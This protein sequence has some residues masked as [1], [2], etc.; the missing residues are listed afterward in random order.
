MYRCCHAEITVYPEAQLNLDYFWQRDVYS[1]DPF[2]DVVEPAEPFALGLQVVNVGKGGAGN[3]TITSAQPEIIENEKGLLIDFKII[4]SQVGADPGTNSL[5]VA[6]GNIAPGETKTAQWDMISS[7]Q[8]KFKEFSATFEHLDDNGDLRTS[9]I[10][11]VNIHELIR[12]LEVTTPTDDGI[13]DYLVNDVPD[14]DNLPDVLYMS[15]GGQAAVT[16]ASDAVFG[17]GGFTRTLTATMQSGWSYIQMADVLPGFELTSVVRSDGKS[18][19]VDGMAWRTNRTFHAGEPGATYENLFHLLDF[20]STGS[21]TLTYAVVDHSAPTLQTVTGIPAGLI[22]TPVDA[23]D[24]T[25]SEFIDAT[26]LSAADLSLQ[27]NGSTLVVPDL[28]I[29][30]LSG[31]TWRVSGLA[32]VTAA[33]GN[34]RLIVD[35]HGVND[36]GGNAGTNSI[37]VD[38]AM[39]ATSPVILTMQ[40]PSPVLRNTVVNTLDVTFSRAMNASSIDWSDLALTR[41]GSTVAL[42]ASITVTQIDAVTYRIGSLAGFTNL[43][44][45]YALTVLAGATEDSLGAAGVGQFTRNWTM[46]T[47]LPALISIEHLSTNPRN[48]VVSSLDV[49]FSEAINPASFDWQDITLTR[50]GGSNL[51]TS[52]VTVEQVDADTWRIKNFNWKV[53][54]DGTYVLTVLGAG[55]SDLA[56]NAGTGSVAETWVMDIVDPLAT[57][58]L[59][60]SPDNGISSTDLRTNT[61][62]LTLTGD[63]PET[64]LAVRL[65]DT[66]TNKE[67]GYANVTGTHFSGAFTLSGPGQHTIRVRAADAAGNLAP[68]SFLEVFVDLTAPGVA[69]ITGISPNPRT[70]SVDTVAVS[71]D[72]AIDASSFTFADLSLTRDGN[73]VALDGTVTLTKGTG[74]GY[75]IAGLG[76]FTGAPGLYQLTVSAA[77]LSDLAGNAGAGSKSASWATLAVLPTGIRGFVY[78]DLDGSGTYNPDSWNPEI[79]IAGRTV[80]LD[81]NNN[82]S[83]DG[84]EVFTTS[85]ADGNYV[86]DN[87]A[88]GTYRVAQE[89]PA[90]WI[91]T[92][93]ASGT[94][95]VV[96]AEGNVVSGADFGNFRTGS[97]SGIVFDD[98]DADGTRDAG[99]DPLGGWTVFLDTNANDL[100]DSGEASVVTGVDGAF[101]FTGIGPGTLLVGELAQAGWQR[102][103]PNKPGTIKSGFIL[104][105]DIGNSQLASIAGAKF[106]DLNGNG[107]A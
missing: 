81:A 102:T 49:D 6:L 14:P 76:A 90:G 97:I 15:T 83:L 105:S 59:A 106:N 58:N 43:E 29:G 19:P 99:E 104:S 66:T 38:W 64:G 27:F 1:D 12:S 28:T 53:G 2:T 17:G 51:I 93:P 77:G 10:K 73:D 16:L 41:N 50:D 11:Q 20:N 75:N 13:P 60:I 9:L 33:D 42:N 46:D 25:F 67:L 35:A 95:S 61:L 24:L 89:L 79:A 96:L 85:D 22:T 37:A 86:F 48:I 34:Y 52:E 88:A 92:G 47:T 5:T 72:E 3:L 87:L 103:T 18:L 54:L 21:Y 91:I 4:G 68:D 23:V 45:N 94:Y 82:G 55:I 26:T 8:G 107:V 98:L 40:A 57:S 65:T 70:T 44:G 84:G 63:L 71:L 7:L 56:G 32:G 100:L 101:S 39:G 36:F 62:S 74:N 80:F 69:S 78:E 31:N 30:Y